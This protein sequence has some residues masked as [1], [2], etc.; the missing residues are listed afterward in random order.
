M[1]HDSNILL[2]LTAFRPISLA[3][4]EEVALMSRVDT[5]YVGTISALHGL[6]SDL[7]GKHHVLELEGR[8]QFSYQNVY[9]DT[10]DRTMY[11]DHHRGKARR[12]KI[13]KRLY[14]DSGLSFLEVKS[15]T[16][17]GKT[18]KRRMPSGFEDA[19]FTAE[20]RAFIKQESDFGNRDLV[21]TLRVSFDRI[22]LVDLERAERVTIDTALRFSLEDQ[23]S[24]ASEL[25]VVEVKSVNARHSDMHRTLLSHNIRRRQFSKYCTGM[26]LLA[27]GVKQ[28]LF[29][30]RLRHIRTL[31][32]VETIT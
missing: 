20:E 32:P 16:N 8:R 17:T 19:T 2:P 23:R 3:G 9:Y 11:H 21:Q 26:A 28:N 5:K 25:L 13:R 18:L 10:A 31:S 1:Q 14:A 29:L 24:V 6:L 22:T 27:S 4:M 7:V 12:Q 30:P 15:K